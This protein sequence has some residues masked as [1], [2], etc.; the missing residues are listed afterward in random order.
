MPTAVVRGDGVV[1]SV[2]EGGATVVHSKK[3]RRW[4]QPVH[5]TILIIIK[6]LSL[7]QSILVLANV[8]LCFVTGWRHALRCERPFIMIIMIII[9]IFPGFVF[10]LFVLVPVPE[11]L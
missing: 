6:G 2:D 3:R 10:A 1:C 8:L 11:H 9:T 7:L 4:I 5:I